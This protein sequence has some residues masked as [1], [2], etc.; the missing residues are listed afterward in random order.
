MPRI[1]ERQA[2]LKQLNSSLFKLTV[3]RETQ[4]EDSESLFKSKFICKR[5]QPRRGSGESLGSGDSLGSEDLRGL[6][7]RG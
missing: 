6:D 5:I 1:S 7:L 3:L 4:L 2:L